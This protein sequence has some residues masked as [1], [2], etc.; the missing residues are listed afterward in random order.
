MSQAFR[1]RALDATVSKPILVDFFASYA[2]MYTMQGLAD[3]QDHDR[4]CQPCRVLTPTLKNLTGPE[5]GFDL[6]TI[7]VDENPEVAAEFQV[8]SLARSS[9][10]IS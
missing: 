4:W 10:P 2:L 7:D 8:S 1:K 5:S 6:M 9:C 3:C